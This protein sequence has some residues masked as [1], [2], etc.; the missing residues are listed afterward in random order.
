[1]V[2]SPML[3]LREPTARLVKRGLMAGAAVVGYVLSPL[4]WWNDALVNIPLSLA[5]AALLE[6]LT[7]L[8]PR[9]GFAL[10]YWASNVAGLALMLLGG[11]GAL[12]GSLSRRSIAAS[13]AAGTA[14]TVLVIAAMEAFM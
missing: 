1:M 6:R 9:A 11:E 12:R 8:D 2:V 14:Y 3:R 4:S 10:A 5:A 7:G 13:L